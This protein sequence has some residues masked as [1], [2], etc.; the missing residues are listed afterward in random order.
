LSASLAAIGPQIHLRQ[1]KHGLDESSDI[2]QAV[3]AFSMLETLSWSSAHMGGVVE[4][5]MDAALATAFVFSSDL[6]AR[7]LG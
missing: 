1:Q 4:V 7:S 6:P 5:S 3:W 2:E